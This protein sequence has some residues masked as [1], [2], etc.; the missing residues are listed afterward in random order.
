MST[1]W[2][3]TAGTNVKK[4]VLKENNFSDKNTFEIN[5]IYD[6][7]KK[8]TLEDPLPKDIILKNVKTRYEINLETDGN[9]PIMS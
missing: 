9:K 2:S 6:T 4:K 7:G 1:V 8:S 5:D 3:F